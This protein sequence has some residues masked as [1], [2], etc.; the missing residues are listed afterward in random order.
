M[1]Q[2]RHCE[3]DLVSKVTALLPHVSLQSTSFPMFAMM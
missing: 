1:A 2:L 3:S